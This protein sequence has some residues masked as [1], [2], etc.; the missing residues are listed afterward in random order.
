MYFNCSLSSQFLQFRYIQGNEMAKRNSIPTRKSCSVRMLLFIVFSSEDYRHVVSV[1]ALL[2][3][4]L[5]STTAGNI[6]FHHT[7]RQ[8]I[9]RIQNRSFFPVLLSASWP[10]QARQSGQQ[11]A[12][13]FLVLFLLFLTPLLLFFQRSGLCIYRRLHLVYH[14]LHCVPI[15]LS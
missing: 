11:S 9:L 2:S 3:L 15:H 10:Y 4:T 12:P 5:H 8:L 14:I 6:S 7:L 13:A 1:C